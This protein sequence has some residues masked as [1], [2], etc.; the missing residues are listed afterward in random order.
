MATAPYRSPASS[1]GIRRALA[2]RLAAGW[3][4]PLEEPQPE[5][6]L[7]VSRS[8]DSRL[9]PQVQAYLTDSLHSLHNKLHRQDFVR[10]MT[11][12]FVSILSPPTR[13]GA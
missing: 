13:T 12:R 4:V 7:E 10:H 9:L 6:K 5:Q 3:A 2:G 1:D 8:Q 11:G